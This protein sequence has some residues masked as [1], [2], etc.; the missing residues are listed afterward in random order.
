MD[1]TIACI[2]AAGLI[3]ISIISMAYYEERERYSLCKRVC[4]QKDLILM[5]CTTNYVECADENGKRTLKPM[6]C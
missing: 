4:F 6:P 2:I 5:R 1:K 3:V